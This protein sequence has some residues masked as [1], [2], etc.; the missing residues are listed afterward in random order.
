MIAVIHGIKRNALKLPQLR[1]AGISI[2]IIIII[3][4]CLR[5]NVLFNL[6]KI[7][8]QNGWTI[9][10]IVN[11]HLDLLGVHLKHENDK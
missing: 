10:G 4:F 7:T 5:G 9:L 1:A 2:K 3:N 6:V 8:E 11:R